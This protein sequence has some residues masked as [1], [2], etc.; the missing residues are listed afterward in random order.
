MAS[1]TQLTNNQTTPPRTEGVGGDSPAI[2]PRA[3][4]TPEREQA[5]R[6][7][8]DEGIGSQKA[9][10]YVFNK[11]HRR[12]AGVVCEEGKPKKPITTTKTLSIQ[13]RAR[14]IL[15][16]RMKMPRGELTR[17]EMIEGC[18]LQLARRHLEKYFPILG[19]AES[20]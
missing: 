3:I 13:K 17:T 11:M 14:G 7:G 2:E 10:R 8:Q 12:A 18:D 20:Q 4:A 9:S 1:S 5:R 16:K 15:C 6:K 19:L